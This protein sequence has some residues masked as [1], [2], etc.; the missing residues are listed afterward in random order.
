M[1]YQLIEEGKFVDALEKINQLMDK[2]PDFPGVAEAY[3]TIRFWLNRLDSLEKL[4]EGKETAD[5]LMREW[6]EFNKY[7]IEKNIIN[8]A[9]YS[10]AMKY[11]FF[12][13]SEHYTRAF[14]NEEST[15]DN[16]DL[17]LNLGICFI[18]LQ[19]YRRAIDTLEYAKSSL[20]S[21]A[22]LLALL[23]EAY[24]NIDEI[25]KSLLCFKEAFFLNPT[26]IDL[27]YITA[28]PVLDLIQ[29]AKN[30][31]PNDDP[32]EWV[33]VFGFVQDIFYIRKKLNSQQVETIKRDIYALEIAYQKSRKEKIEETKI[34]PRLINKYL[35][36]LEYYEYQHYDLEAINEIR[37]RLLKLDKDI[38]KDYFGRRKG[39]F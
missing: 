23:G 5:F 4:K 35:W 31:K 28:K 15:V 27:R 1:A 37:A 14:V 11:I 9:A 25:P 2:N 3:R 38:F 17:L 34:I 22:K 16:F 18:T 29:I 36:M 7:S 13:A 33:P 30:L 32:R 24:Y 6:N 20:R 8:S 26:E 12:K 21:S 19:D 10:A 39:D